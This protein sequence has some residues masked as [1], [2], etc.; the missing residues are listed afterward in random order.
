[1]MRSNKIQSLLAMG[2]M[3]LLWN[4]SMAAAFVAEVGYGDDKQ[5]P[6]DSLI[7]E[8]EMGKKDSS[9][10]SRI[11]YAVL[12]DSMNAL[13][14]VMDTR[15]HHIGESF[16]KHWADHL[17]IEAGAGLEQITPPSESYRFNPLNVGRL[18]I[19]KQFNKYHTARMTL[20][21]GWGRQQRLNKILG[22][23]GVKLDYMY[24][25][26]SYFAGYNPSRLMNL[27][28]VIGLGYQNSTMKGRESGQSFEGHLGVQAKFYTGPHGYFAIEPYVGIA[29]DK[30]DLSED[31]N[32][33]KSDFFYGASLSYIYYIRN[34]L[35]RESRRRIIDRSGG[36]EEMLNDST[37]SSWRKPWFVEFS[38]GISFLKTPALSLTETG[39]PETNLSVGKWFSPVIGLRASATVRSTTWNKYSS[40]EV[41]VPS[42]TPAYQRNAHSIYAAARMEALFNPFG[43]SRSFSWDSRF[44][45]FLMGGYELGW[46]EKY[47]EQDLS[48]HS[49]SYTG[50]LNVWARLSRG[51]HLFLEPRYAYTE[52]KIPYT[53]ADASEV[54]ND[55]YFCFSIG[56][57]VIPLGR[58]SKPTEEKPSDVG[59]GRLTVGLGGGFNV[60]TTRM[61]CNEKMPFNYNGRVFAEYRFN[62]VSSVQ[63]TVELVHLSNTDTQEFYDLNKD[64]P[65]MDYL[66]TSREGLMETS[67]NFGFIS[68][69]YLF[70]VSQ[71]VN[72]RS[73]LFELECFLGPTLGMVM[74]GKNELVGKERL[75]EHHVAEAKN[76]I[77]SK[78]FFGANVGM[79]L[80][81]NAWKRMSFWFS[82]TYY[83]MSTSAFNSIDL[84]NIKYLEKLDFG[85]QY[86]ETFNVGV[87]YR[88]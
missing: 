9:M 78:M 81:C 45:C 13:D 76:L 65:D 16:G 33:R 30:V 87:Q 77:K 38:N 75:Q 26:S 83:W 2:A 34:N 5:I 85:V 48:C 31:R 6:N 57:R 39:G 56:L 20:H 24:N 25:L 82:P 41:T 72:R 22:K 86:L 36:K 44:G 1:M 17:F 10:Y 79:K 61:N 46:I 43:F 54:Y 60:F 67:C 8:D 14:Y 55:S 40:P 64:Y 28:S 18:G 73:S 68:A 59:S 47:Q 62:A 69:N 32:W 49:E 27:S 51:V 3:L 12:K 74:N 4:V 29:S 42:Y 71:M 19:G 58:K 63:A 50:G 37:L 7:F 70:N 11:N 53:N 23:W 21:F 15:Y 88:F 35:S 66:R 52:Y 84:A 80:T